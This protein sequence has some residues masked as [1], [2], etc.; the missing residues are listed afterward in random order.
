MPR[1]GSAMLRPFVCVPACVRRDVFN[2]QGYAG[3]RMRP[4]PAAWAGMER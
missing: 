1:D 3:R 4:R 2:A